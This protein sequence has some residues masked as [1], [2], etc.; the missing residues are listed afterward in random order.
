VAA[1]SPSTKQSIQALYSDFLEAKNLKPRLGQKQMIAEVA[2]ILARIGDSDSAPIGFIEAGTGTGK[3]LAYLIGALPYAMEREM[4]L[5]ISTATVS[6]QA[7][8]IEKDIPDLID[9]TGLMLS[10]ALAKGRRRYLCP[11]RLEAALEMLNEGQAIYPDELTLVFD[12]DDKDVVSDLAKAWAQGEWTGDMDQIP[13][14]ISDSVKTAITTDHRRCQGRS[15][16]HFKAC[17]YFNERDSWLDADL[18]VINHDLLMSDLKLGGGLILPPLERVILIVDEAHQLA[19]VA[20][21]QFTAHCRIAQSLGAIKTIERVI[22]VLQGIL[23]ADHRIAN[24]L[25]RLPEP[26]EGFGHILANWGKSCLE[27]LKELPDSAFAFQNGGSRY[28]LQL[29]ESFPVMI[30]GFE[31]VTTTLSRIQKVCDWLKSLV[32]QSDQDLMP[33]T[34][35]ELLSEQILMALGRLETIPE[36]IAAFSDD[37]TQSGDARWLRVGQ[38]VRYAT[39]DDPTDLEFWVSPMEPAGALA[40][41]LWGRIGA[42][43]LTSATLAYHGRFEVPAGTLGLPVNSGLIVDGAFHYESQGRLVISKFS[44][45]PRDDQ[46]HAGRIA[47]YLDTRVE[48]NIGIL[49]LFT[50][51]RLCF[52]VEELLEDAV[53]KVTLVQGQRPLALLLQEHAKQRKRGMMSI[54]FGLQSL[55]EGI[56]LPGDLANE[57]VITRLPFQPPDDP[58]EATLAEYLRNQGRD[59]FTEL[60]LPSATIRLRQAVGRLIRSETDT[61][62]VTMLD[63]RLVNT[64]WGQSLLKELPAFEF[65]EE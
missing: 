59:P 33:E 47:R 16:R 7:Q 30:D 40:D 20:S 50:S 48:G 63:S 60:S 41:A 35:A 15:C 53:R 1:I 42:C 17:P 5:V 31:S 27:K 22:S 14:I 13:Q 12:A 43:V 37:A 18:L 56:D 62:Q 58:R 6:L 32:S 52:Q 4:P 44:G 34:D 26:L 9:S 10:F 57:V 45:D 25:K 8:L 39:P 55:A 38:D 28:R 46:S 21:D 29:S 23:P 2:R 24:D 19:R 64:R 65:I 49:V 54:I 36:L 51:W 11:I 3:T 61:G